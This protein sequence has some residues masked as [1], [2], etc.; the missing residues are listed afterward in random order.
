MVYSSSTKLTTKYAH[1]QRIICSE[2]IIN[3]ELLITPILYQPVIA[4]IEACTIEPNGYIVFDFGEELCGGIE[5]TTH[6]F[7]GTPSLRVVFGESVMETLSNIGQKNSTND[8]AI[9]DSVVPVVINSR[10]RVGQTG[11]RFVK[12]QAM[13]SSVKIISIR[14]ACDIRDIPYRGNFESNDNRLNQIWKTGAR[15]VHLCMQ[16][17]LWDG[18]KRD[19]LVWLGDMHAEVAAIA[20]V[21]GD[22]EIVEDS[23]KFISR[24]TPADTWVNTIPSYSLWWIIIQRD[25]YHQTGNL[26]PL[27]EQKDYIINTIKHIAMIINEDGTDNIEPWGLLSDNIYSG[28][29]VDWESYATEDSKNGFYSVLMVALNAG[30]ELCDILDS[31]NVKALCMDRIS[32]IKKIRF[33]KSDNMQISSLMYLAGLDDSKEK[34]KNILT[35]NHLA[36]M[37]AYLGY[38]TLF[39]KG[40]IGDVSGAIDIING[41]WGR[42][43]DLGATTFWEVFDYINSLDAIGIDKI[44]PDG[45]KDIHGDGG[46]LWYKGYRK[47]LCHGWACGPTPFLSKYV[48]GITPVEPGFKKV[49]IKPNL[50]NLEYVCGKYP[51][52]YGDINIVAEQKNG[53]VKY[54][55]DVPSEIEVLE[56]TENNKYRF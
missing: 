49:C 30:C 35:Q 21:F 39:A 43:I 37:S 51:T 8:H 10:F 46:K 26:K 27:L 32:R 12:I 41:Y 25:W 47:S 50:G 42:M 16:D 1:P 23:L 44:V 7:P 6:E 20:A 5:I 34:T 33:S 53:K 24:I 9:R 29:F 40:K 52:P 13:D 4:N 54:N 56:E 36:G 2:N 48:L 19:R 3:E 11:F 28:Y 55:I 17:Y 14:A 38:Y 15:T 18:I 31:A 22:N 45:K